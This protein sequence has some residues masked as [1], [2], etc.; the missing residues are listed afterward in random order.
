VPV[1]AMW[2]VA[3][4]AGRAV[5]LGGLRWRWGGACGGGGGG[6]GGGDAGR[7]GGSVAP[8]KGFDDGSS[9]RR[10][11]GVC[12]LGFVAWRHA[13]DVGGGELSVFA[14]GG[15]AVG[16]GEC[17]DG[18]QREWE[19]FALSRASVAGGCFAER[20]GGGVGAGGWAAEH[21]VGRA[22]P[23]GEGRAAWGVS[24]AGDGGRQRAGESADGVR[25]GGLR[26]RRGLRAAFDGWAVR[27]GSGDQA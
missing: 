12:R 11:D 19:V 18:G 20:R 26:V 16:A 15:G 8:A 3:P 27:A 13:H 9:S 24:R 10:T 23:S 2:P 1:A 4:A 14:A 17:G 21:V 5:A 22:G 6:A 25:V 7:G